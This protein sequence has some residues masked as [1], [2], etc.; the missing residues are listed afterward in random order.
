MYPLP[1]YEGMPVIKDPDW[2]EA[3]QQAVVEARVDWVATELTPGM[4]LLEIA[5]MFRS[6]DRELLDGLGSL[7]GHPLRFQNEKWSQTGREHATEY[8]KTHPQK[9]LRSWEVRVRDRCMDPSVAVGRGPCRSGKPIDK[10]VVPAIR[11]FRKAGVRAKFEP[12]QWPAPVYRYLY[13]VALEGAGTEE[14]V[15]IRRTQQRS[16]ELLAL[17]ELRQK[18]LLIYHSVSLMTLMGAWYELGASGFSRGLHEHIKAQAAA[19]REVD[20]EELV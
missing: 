2:N 11:F 8:L 13:A 9:P 16:G 19:E 10:V 20:I 12:G 3:A 15:R 4:P 6:C 18:F 7:Q 1:L 5:A 14:W 17:V